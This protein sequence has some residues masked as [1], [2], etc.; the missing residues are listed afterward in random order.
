VLLVATFACAPCAPLQAEE[1]GRL[2]FAPEQRNALDA[3]RRARIPDKPATT[4]IE[5]PLTNVNGFVSRSNGKSTVWINGE[6][7][8]E[9]SQPEGVQVHPRRNDASRVTIGI[10]ESET[11]VDLKVGQSF[12]R[13]TG[14]VRDALQGGAVRITRPKRPPQ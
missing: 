11:Q 13:A 10:G 5:S 12:D 8:T 1:L 4:A 14:E 3:R 7:M 2:F 9:G 6:A